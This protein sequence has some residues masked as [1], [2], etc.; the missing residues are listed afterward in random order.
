[1]THRTT[2]RLH[3]QVEHLRAAPTGV[4]MSSRMIGPPA[5]TDEQRALAGDPVP[6]G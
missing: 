2:S 1:M 6:V 5:V 3:D 4:V